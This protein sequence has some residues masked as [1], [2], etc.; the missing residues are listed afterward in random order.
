[1]Q[2]KLLENESIHRILNK[3]EKTIKREI[4]SFPRNYKLIHI[5]IVCKNAGMYKESS[6]KGYIEILRRYVCTLYNTVLFHKLFLDGVYLMQ[7]TS[8]EHSEFKT[9]K[10]TKPTKVEEFNSPPPD[11]VAYEIAQVTIQS[12]TKTF[13][14]KW[15]DILKILNKVD[16]QI[17][18]K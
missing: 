8:I 5:E 9:N 3:V 16:E 2:S 7:Q 4:N 10:L 14:R 18:N 15:I 17:D 1:M 12:I 13:L 6:Y 11:G